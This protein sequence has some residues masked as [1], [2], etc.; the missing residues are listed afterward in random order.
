MNARTYVQRQSTPTVMMIRPVRFLSNPQTAESNSFQ[1]ID[2]APAPNV[3]QEGASQEFDALVA[4]LEAADVEV[5]AFDG[6]TE[7]HSPDQVFPN[8]W[9][10]FHADGTVV[11]YPMLAKNRRTERRMDIVTALEQHHG[12]RINEIIDFTRF[13]RDG[14]FLEATGSICMDR[15][16]RIA[17]ACLSP[18]TDRMLLER[19]GQRLGYEIM[20]FEATGRS[21]QAVYHTNVMMCIGEK[22]ALICA[23]AIGD[24]AE[25]RRVLARLESTGHETVTIDH[26]QMAEFAGNMLEIESRSGEKILAMS[27]RAESTLGSAQKD[28]LSRHTRIV[29]AR[30]DTIEDSAGGSVRCML[31]EVHL[32]RTERHA[33]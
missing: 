11:L 27:T 19:F 31:A 30:I 2:E 9:V 8:N 3:A 18:R 12:F 14:R 4:A 25:R 17:Y 6:V 22:F 10:S 13:E 20:A 1:N 29:S 5:I 33:S 28:I 7:P 15:V 32:P 26:P 16:N 21:G 24:D 23:D